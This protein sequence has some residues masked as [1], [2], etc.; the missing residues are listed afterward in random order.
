MKVLF[1]EGAETILTGQ[2]VVPGVLQGTTAREQVFEHAALD[3]ALKQSLR[4]MRT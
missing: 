2:F 3:A 4:E 1:G